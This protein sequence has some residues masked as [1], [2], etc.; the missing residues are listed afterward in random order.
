MWCLFC[1][2]TGRS[3]VTKPKSFDNK[4]PSIPESMIFLPGHQS[5]LLRIIY[6]RNSKYFEKY[7]GFQE[8][9]QP[10]Q[11]ISVGSMFWLYH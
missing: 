11:G 6:W 2:K 7:F 3:I 4:L 9:V 5:R 8:P 10:E 1:K